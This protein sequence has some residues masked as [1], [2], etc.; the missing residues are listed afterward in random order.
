MYTYI[1][2]Y[3]HI[4]IHLCFSGDAL[5]LLRFSRRGIDDGK[6]GWRRRTHARLVARHAPAAARA[7]GQARAASRRA[8]ARGI[9][10]YDIDIDR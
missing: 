3:I 4:Y 6:A 1:Y 9:Y 2:I 5:R 7:R 10:R 8:A